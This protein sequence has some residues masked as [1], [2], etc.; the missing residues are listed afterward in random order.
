MLE[1][2]A[3]LLFVLA[4]LGTWLFVVSPSHNLRVHNQGKTM[5]QVRSELVL[6]ASQ[7]FKLFLHLSWYVLISSIGLVY[8]FVIEPLVAIL[9]LVYGL[10][11]R[12]LAVLMIAILAFAITRFF[13]DMRVTRKR[14][15]T[16]SLG[17]RYWYWAKRV[18]FALPTF[19]L[20]YL[21]LVV[22]GILP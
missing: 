2:S 14:N 16:I 8:G 9:A 21:F 13:Y 3:Y 17:N 19:Y 22:V 4:I 12:P 7:D 5:H 11:Y 20:W 1:F 18:F 10:G 15:I 6:K